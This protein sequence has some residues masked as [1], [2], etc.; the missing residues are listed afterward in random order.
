MTPYKE[1][2]KQLSR[3]EGRIPHAYYDSMGYLTIGVGHLI[4]PRLGGRISETVIDILLED[5]I[6]EKV[7]QVRRALPWSMQLDEV[8]FGAL[9]NMAFQLGINGL[10]QFKKTLKF[11][12][13][14]KWQAAHD[15]ALKCYTSL[16]GDEWPEQT[17]DRAKR[18]AK[19]ILTGEWQ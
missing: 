4:D 11:I 16:K 2:V 7:L 5:D 1:L 12:Q 13:E 9:V 10:L 6:A 17:P 14:G 18:V 15:E 8:R 19:Q 3:D